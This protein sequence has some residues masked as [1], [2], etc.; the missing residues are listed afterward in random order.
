METTRFGI[1]IRDNFI[2]VN[3][4]RK[5]DG[6]GDP[7]VANRQTRAAQTQILGSTKNA[8]RLTARNI[9]LSNAISK[10]GFKAALGRGSQYARMKDAIMRKAFKLSNN[11]QRA[12][13]GFG[14]NHKSAIRLADHYEKLVSRNASEP[15]KLE[16]LTKLKE[17]LST[18]QAKHAGGKLLRGMD[19]ELAAKGPVQDMLKYVEHEISSLP[20]ERLK[21]AYRLMEDYPALKKKGADIPARLELLRK[22][23]DLVLTAREAGITKSKDMGLLELVQNEIGHLDQHSQLRKELEQAVENKATFL[24]PVRH[25]RMEDP[26]ANMKARKEH[27]DFVQMTRLDPIRALHQMSMN[28]D[29]ETFDRGDLKKVGDKMQ[30][31][32]GL[33]QARENF[34]KSMASKEQAPR[35]KADIT[36]VLSEP[37][38]EVIHFDEKEFSIVVNRFI[39]AE[40]SGDGVPEMSEFLMSVLPPMDSDERLA[41]VT[42]DGRQFKDQLIQLMLQAEPGLQTEGHYD[43]GT[44]NFDVSYESASPR[45]KEFVDQVYHQTACEIG[46]RQ[47]GEGML[48]IGSHYYTKQEEL[49]RGSYGT[50]FRYECPETGHEIAVKHPNNDDPMPEDFGNACREVRAHRQAMGEGHDNIVGLTSA[51]RTQNG[52]LLVAM[53]LAPRG[54]VYS[55]AGKITEALKN[56]QISPQAAT[57]IRLTL[58]KDMLQGMQHMQESRQMMHLD[59]KPLNYF[60]GQNGIAKLGD[61]GTAKEGSQ[62]QVKSFEV[63]NPRWQSPETLKEIFNHQDGIMKAEKELRTLFAQERKA[64]QKELQE[65][66]V[67]EQE[68]QR[69][70]E[71]LENKQEAALEEI[72]QEKTFKLTGQSDVW[73]LGMTAYELFV[74]EE[75]FYENGMFGFEIEKKVMEFGESPENRLRSRDL[76]SGK[77][78]EGTTSL[79]RLLNQMLTPNPENR[80]G[81]SD[82]LAS[83]LFK[84]PGVDS[85]E[86]RLLIQA[87]TD[88]SQDLEKIRKASEELGI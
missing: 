50:V 84:E 13:I 86:A 68:Q 65:Q 71:E 35:L 66:K 58:L 2:P 1:A 85:Q 41:F 37:S 10:E 87:L 29:I 15:E 61:F 53:E 77:N 30:V 78:S 83:P 51:I 6:G 25:T 4:D 75:P 43:S 14:S 21:T 26:I 64:V 55:L 54:D 47:I 56:K 67:S 20:G 31:K 76:V 23:E 17:V 52:E 72:I 82:A 46:D 60:L 3:V 74:K 9:T 44:K 57:V 40:Q 69:L 18:M 24:K 63:E 79:D 38:L 11:G 8:T 49:G 32:D 45:L 36:P 19:P 59:I 81:F 28:L 34:Q 39:T 42:S 5:V 22:V 70:L 27:Q 80:I 88:K 12:E 62:M 48:K 16:A 7:S 73:A 33:D